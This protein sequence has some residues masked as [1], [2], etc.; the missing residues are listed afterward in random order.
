MDNQ[1]QIEINRAHQY[2]AQKDWERM[3]NRRELKSL[4]ATTLLMIAA[5]G[6]TVAATNIILFGSL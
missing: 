5:V 6:A 4:L 1:R 2:L 3:N